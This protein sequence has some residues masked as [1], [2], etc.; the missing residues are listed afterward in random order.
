MNKKV[1]ILIIATIKFG[2]IFGQK[3]KVKNLPNFD[4]RKYH[5]GFILAY[6][7]SNFF[8]K[9]IPDYT[10]SDSLFSIETKPVSAFAVGPVGSLNL[11]KNLRVRTGIIL[12]FS[13]RILNYSFWVKDTIKEFEKKV[14][15]VY[16]EVP[17]HFKL[18][19]DRINNFAVYALFGA[20]Y[21]LDWASQRHVDVKYN[22]EDI[23]KIKRSNYAY[24]VGGGFDFFLPYFKFGIELKYS[25][26]FNNVLIKNNTLF[27]NPIDKL[28]NKMWMISFTFEG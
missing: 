14:N 12:A 27:S 5:W 15:S 28:R 6:N 1:F 2:C 22:F 26:G 21:G 25:G 23:V 19:T 13:D 18:R 10:F 16:T 11:S 24:E 8:M 9:T 20:K 3:N 4:D 7:E 17:L